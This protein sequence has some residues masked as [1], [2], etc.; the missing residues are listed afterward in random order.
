M[1]TLRGIAASG[2]VPEGTQQEGEA[3]YCS[4]IE[5]SSGRIDWNM[6]A[7]DIC[8][9]IRAYTPWPLAYTGHKGETLYILEA[10]P[11]TGPAPEPAGVDCPGRVLCADRKNG[12][13]IRT[14][15]GILAARRLQYRARKA[16]PWQAFLNG[17]RDFSGIA[18]G[19]ED[20]QSDE[21]L[22]S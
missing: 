14:G 17:A 22:R 15:G 9:R 21:K 13:L 1:E 6:S 16:L 8:A 20:N 19:L 10:A 11:Y 18:L 7:E 2:T 4:R 12:I 3:S 5:K